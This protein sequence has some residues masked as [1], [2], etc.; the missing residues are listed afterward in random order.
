V[1]YTFIFI[2]LIGFLASCGSSSSFTKAC[3]SSPGA[4]DKNTGTVSGKEIV[5]LGLL[6]K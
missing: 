6:R 4:N 1:K 2:C 3:A 5:K